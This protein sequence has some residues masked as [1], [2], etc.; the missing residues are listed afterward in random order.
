MQ[1]FRNSA[2]LFFIVLALALP[3]LA[4][5]APKDARKA[6]GAKA[7][8]A[9]RSA[10]SHDDADVR[11]LAAAQWG[12]IGNPAAVPLLEKAL[13]D[14]N[15]YVRIAAAR[16]LHDLGDGTGLRALEE[17]VSIVPKSAKT[18]ETL[19]AVEEM[20][21]V[22]RNK[23]RVEAL[24]ALA[25]M[26]DPSSRPVLERVRRDSDGAVRDACTLALARLGMGGVEEFFAA[27]EDPDP[28]VRSKAVRLL[29]ETRSPS[30]IARLKP[31]ADDTEFAVRAA[32]ME[33]L[34]D[35]GSAD[36][37]PILEDGLADQNERVRAKAV[38]AAGEI[39]D[40]A[41]VALLESARKTTNAHIELLA[42]RGLARRGEPVDA[43]LAERALGRPDTD[44]QLLAIETLEAAGGSRAVGALESALDDRDFKVRVRA[45]AALILLLRKPASGKGDA[46]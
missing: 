39:P 29:G 23:V 45:A 9:L 12:R 3:V 30:L 1:S 19:A 4:G 21:S 5:D 46:R 38:E 41:S 43:A 7:L 2:R 32:V 27:L 15:P 6:L 31:L 22:A 35:I 24:R 20:R 40:R 18:D 14:R 34:G 28:E 11:A 25:A 10:L 13:K 36:A 44:T 26:G 42:L 16:S 33:A 37:L 8:D 17:I